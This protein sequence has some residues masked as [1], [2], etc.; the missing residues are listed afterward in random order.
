MPD[1]AI[2]VD[3]DACPVKDEIYK[4][5]RR[6]S[7]DACGSE[8]V[9]PHADGPRI[10]FVL[11]DAGRTLLTT[12]SRSAVV[13]DVVVMNDIRWPRVWK[14]AQRTPTAKVSPRT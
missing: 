11:V 3:A 1:M 5:A 13:G 7:L 4:V 6:L 10:K 9:H 14:R 2:Y 8:L 12:G